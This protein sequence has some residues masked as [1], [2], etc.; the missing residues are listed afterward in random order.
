MLV[1][2]PHDCFLW[3]ALGLEYIKRG[4]LIEA[5]TSF[6]QVLAADKNYVGTYYH[7]ARTY[8]LTEQIN[9]AIETYEQGIQI[10]QQLNDKHA[11]QELRMALEDM[12]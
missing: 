8:V 2:A 3:H 9:L 7:L 11:L 10:A 12:E 5:I 4:E 1:Q 6:K